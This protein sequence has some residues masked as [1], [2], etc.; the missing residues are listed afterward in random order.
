MNWFEE[1]TKKRMNQGRQRTVELCQGYWPRKVIVTYPN[2]SWKKFPKE[3][4]IPSTLNAM[5]K[6][7]MP[8]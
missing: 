2:K 5:H 6:P 1:G 7:S 3:V 8:H 4:T